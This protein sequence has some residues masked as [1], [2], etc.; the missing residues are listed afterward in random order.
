MRDDGR[1]EGCFING[2]MKNKGQNLAFYICEGE[3]PIFT[4]DFVMEADWYHLPYVDDGT[5]CFKE[6]TSISAVVKFILKEQMERRIYRKPRVDKH[7]QS[8][9]YGTWYEGSRNIITLYTGQCLKIWM[10]IDT[11]LKEMG[12]EVK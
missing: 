7:G 2:S 5:C 4:N 1:R 9:I 8:Q 11:V 3:L 10:T 6:A 12:F